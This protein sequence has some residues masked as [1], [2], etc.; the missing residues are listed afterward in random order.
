LKYTPFVLFYKSIVNL[1][2]QHG[3][4][5]GITNAYQDYVSELADKDV[6]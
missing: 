1:A 5:A 6:S 3:K 4:E 2:E